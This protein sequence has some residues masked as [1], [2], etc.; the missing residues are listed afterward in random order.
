MHDGKPTFLQIG[1]FRLRRE[2][3]SGYYDPPDSDYLEVFVGSESPYSIR[4][5]D[6]ATA[7]QI[8]ADHKHYESRHLL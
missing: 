2:R 3:Y 1:P 6:E 8:R 4:V 7:E 5:N